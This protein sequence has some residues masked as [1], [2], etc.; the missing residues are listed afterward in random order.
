METRDKLRSM[1]E[2]KRVEERRSE[3]RRKEK[4]QEGE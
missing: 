4:R 3:E 2:K 1:R